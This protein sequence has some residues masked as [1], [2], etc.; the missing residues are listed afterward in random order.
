MLLNDVFQ[1]VT[2]CYMVFLV[3]FYVF[4]FSF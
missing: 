3:S 4:Y 2:C 1:L